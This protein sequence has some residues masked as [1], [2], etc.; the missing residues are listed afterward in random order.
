MDTAYSP[1]GKKNEYRI[2]MRKPERKKPLGRSR[3]RE[4][5]WHDMD[6][7]DLTQDR[8]QRRVLENIIMNQ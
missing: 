3:C 8:N 2:W 7:I 4:I 6:W 5:G 1:N